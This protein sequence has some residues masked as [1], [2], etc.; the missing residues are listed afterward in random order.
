MNRDDILTSSLS[1]CHLRLFVG[2]RH[3][4]LLRWLAYRKASAVQAHL[5]KQVVGRLGWRSGSCHWYQ[6]D[7]RS[8]RHKPLFYL[9]MGRNGSGGGCVR[10]MGRPCG[11]AYETTARHKGFGQHSSGA[12][13]NARPFRQFAHCHSGSCA[14]SCNLRILFQ[15][16]QNSA[17]HLPMQ[18]GIL[19]T[20][21]VSEVRHKHCLTR[22][23]QN[24]F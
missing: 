18:G 4:R 3:G 10:N 9:A 5:A 16:I 11:I 22:N 13:R 1:P 21:K 17:L 24:L 19:Q 6:H 12:R 8:L 2:E 23:S 20:T 7:F 14:I 15:I